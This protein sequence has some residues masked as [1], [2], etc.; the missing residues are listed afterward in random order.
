MANNVT[1]AKKAGVTPGKLVLIAMLAVVLCGVLYLQFGPIGGQTSTRVA[2]PAAAADST[3]RTTTAT[4]QAAPAAAADDATLRK[5]T[6]AVATWQSP[7]LKPV[8]EYDPFAL[9]ASFPQPGHADNSAALAQ[10]AAAA[11][12]AAAEQAAL[13]AERSKSESELQGLRQQGVHVIIKRDDH[14]VAMVGDQE[15]HVG[16]QIDGFT[17]IAID[18]DGV[19]VAKD[20][21]Q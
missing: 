16:D 11:E 15:V 13:Q 6:G 5:K 19:R 4:A 9:P 10:S 14:F 20:L 21:R 8:I 17:V 7:D 2:L 12:A 18:A 1:W 3:I